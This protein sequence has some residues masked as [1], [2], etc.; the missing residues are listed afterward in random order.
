MFLHSFFHHAIGI[1]D[2]I[3][4]VLLP[5]NDNRAKAKAFYLDHS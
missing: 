1:D 5:V 3:T 4:V 2:N